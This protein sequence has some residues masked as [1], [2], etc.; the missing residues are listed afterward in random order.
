MNKYIL[1]FLERTKFFILA[2]LCFSL[3][4]V[5]NI[6]SRRNVYYSGSPAPSSF[7]V[8]NEKMK[9]H[10]NDNGVIHSLVRKDFLNN[11]SKSATVIFNSPMNYE[12]CIELG[13]KGENFPG[14]DS[15][16]QLVELKNE[17]IVLKSIG[18]KYNILRNISLKDQSIIVVD[19]FMNGEGMGQYYTTINGGNG[20]E[21]SLNNRNVSKFLFTKN[22]ILKQ[23]LN[24]FHYPGLFNLYK[25]NINQS[26]NT[27]KDDFIC[28]LDNSN[29]L[30]TVKNNPDSINFYADSRQINMSSMKLC[31]GVMTTEISVLP[32]TYE[33]INN[34]KS[35]VSGD[36]FFKNSSMIR[37]YGILN[38]INKPISIIF[39]KFLS[40]NSNFLSFVL[41]VFIFALILSPGFYWIN[42][43]KEESKFIEAKT[44]R[45]SKNGFQSQTLMFSVLKFHV[46]TLA[47]TFLLSFTSFYYFFKVIMG[48]NFYLSNISF[49]WLK[50]FSLPEQG[51]I[52]N[53]YGFLNFSFSPFANLGV[54]KLI[55]ML[56]FYFF[57][58]KDQENK[59]PFLLFVIGLVAMMYTSVGQMLGYSLFLIFKEIL[60]YIFQIFERKSKNDLDY[61]QL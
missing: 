61:Q 27:Q 32:N 11:Y 20:L 6:M 14:K 17:T 31:E 50:D 48:E 25:K 9:I 23:K 52:L 53:L 22:K 58:F 33:A 59:N 57:N 7:S 18:S 47:V 34:Y 19:N 40:K 21:N 28:F 10:I 41:S 16:W 29:F 43:R 15:K 2:V 39:E 36:R 49:L 3:S 35:Q 44:I 42:K 8:E 45:E 54:V 60:V 30:V 4:G 24:I 12:K 38:V 26:F 56:C 37:E 5:A 13:F 1:N 46:K 55:F 51:S